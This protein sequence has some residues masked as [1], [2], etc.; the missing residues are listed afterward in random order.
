M[1]IFAVG[2]HRRVS[3]GPRWNSIR[4][5]GCLTFPLDR[6]NWFDGMRARKQSHVHYRAD[7]YFHDC[8]DLGV[9]VGEC[10]ETLLVGLQALFHFTARICFQV[11][12][13]SQDSNNPISGSRV[14]GVST[15]LEFG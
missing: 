15:H 1:Q 10:P 2:V 4:N 7:F 3:I 12:P 5:Y 9:E 11:L 8:S 14:Y 13:C 6:N